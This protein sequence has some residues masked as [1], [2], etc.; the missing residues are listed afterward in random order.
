[1]KTQAKGTT[2]KPAPKLVPK[3]LMATTKESKP[4]LVVETPEWPQAAQDIGESRSP[5]AKAST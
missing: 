5:K 1:M 3:T 4:K 2:P